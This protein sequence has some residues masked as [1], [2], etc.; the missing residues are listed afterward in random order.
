MIYTVDKNV[1]AAYIKPSYENAKVEKVG[2]VVLQ[3]N[4]TIKYR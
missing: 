3:H 2:L 4:S 1:H